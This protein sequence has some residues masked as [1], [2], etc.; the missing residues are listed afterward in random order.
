MNSMIS[1]MLFMRFSGHFEE[2]FVFSGKSVSA[3]SWNNS[4]QSGKSSFLWI[5]II[6]SVIFF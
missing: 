3:A 1:T 2:I 6:H 4:T 5:W